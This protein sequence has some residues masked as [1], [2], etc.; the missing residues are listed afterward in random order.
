MHKSSSPSPL[1]SAANFHLGHKLLKHHKRKASHG[2]HSDD[3]GRHTKSVKV[4]GVLHVP[5]GLVNGR[6]HKK[7]R[8]SHG[9]AEPNGLVNGS[10]SGGIKFAALQEQRKQLPITKGASVF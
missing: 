1:K 5:H 7:A 6:K 10:S 8:H 3:D 9:D 4:N 2:E